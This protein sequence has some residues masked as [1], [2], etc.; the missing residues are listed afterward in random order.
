[1]NRLGVIRS[2]LKKP[3]TEKVYSIRHRFVLVWSGLLPSL[4][5]PVR[6]PYGGWWL[7]RHDECSTAVFTGNF[8][9]GEHR[10]VE[11][12]VKKGMTVLDIGAHNGFYTLLAAKKVGPTGKVMAF[13]PSPRERERLLIHLRLNRLRDRVSVAPVALGRE[14][15]ESTFFVVE[16]RD[17]GCNSLRRPVVS[18]PTREVRVPVTSLDTFL[19]QRN[20][21]RVDFIKMDVEGAEL[22]V[23]WG[24]EQLLDRRPRPV[25]LAELVDSR[26]LPWGYRASAIYDFLVGKDYR[27]F[28]ITKEGL[29]RAYTRTDQFEGNLVAFPD[30]RICEAI[31]FSCSDVGDMFATANSESERR[32]PSKECSRPSLRGNVQIH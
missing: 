16:G 7:A 8:E 6:L 1:M 23:L 21:G 14:T 27:W 19:A 10:F 20:M 28:A 15:R 17:T 11:R 31:D 22:E 24:A 32:D 25:I 12:F 3:W 2:F 4:P 30:E 26:T 29:L 5:L 9:P 18:E 13:E